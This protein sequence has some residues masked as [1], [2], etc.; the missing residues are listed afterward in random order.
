M[1][2]FITMIMAIAL[3]T[4]GSQAQ[5]QRFRT[6]R[7][8]NGGYVTI[9]KGSRKYNFFL[10]GGN[11][12]TEKWYTEKRVKLE[13]Q[14]KMLTN[15][16]SNTRS[17]SRSLRQKEKMN[18]TKNYPNNT[19]CIVNGITRNATNLK[20]AFMRVTACM[21]S[22]RCFISSTRRSTHLMRWPIGNGLKMNQKI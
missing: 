16:I 9:E 13:R 19:I 6:S 5:Q 2:R 18:L 12:E 1:K 4:L 11:P 3:C 7:L 17:L 10:C 22:T 21:C 20:H 8:I 15:T 14:Q